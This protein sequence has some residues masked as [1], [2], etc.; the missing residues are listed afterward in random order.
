MYPKNNNNKLQS[1][2]RSKSKFGLKK[3]LGG[4]LPQYM[5]LCV[6]YWQNLEII[7]E[8]VTATCTAV[9]NLE[10]TA[11]LG[12]SWLNVPVIASELF[13]SLNI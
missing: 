1:A 12:T 8:Y 10:A 9:W 6:L 4:M 5:A 13:S 11:S 3:F 2:L 7:R